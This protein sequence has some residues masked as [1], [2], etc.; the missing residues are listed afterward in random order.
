MEVMLEIYRTLKTLKMEWKAK[1]RDGADGA[2][3]EDG[4]EGAKERER[5]RGEESDKQRRRRE[6]EERIK[7]AQ[8]LYFVETRCR[9]D[10]VMVSSSLSCTLSL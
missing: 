10:D 7:K 8:E 9:M 1:A 2:Q 4:E 3:G 5:E 6:E